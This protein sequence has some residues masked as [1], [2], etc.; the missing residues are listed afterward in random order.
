MS[1][2]HTGHLQGFDHAALRRGWQVYKEVC[3]ACHSLNQLHWRQLVGVVMTEEEAKE[4]AAEEEY[5]D[6][7]NGEGEIED[8]PGKL[9]DPLPRPYPNE[10]AAR[11]GNNGAYPPDLSLISKAREAGPDY[12][13]GLMTGYRDPPAGI[14]LR[15]GLY[16]NVYF[17]GGAIAMTQ[18]LS[19]EMIEYE[20]GTESSVSQMAKD[21]AVFL[22]W[23]AEPEMDQRKKFG[24]K[25]IMLLTMMSFSTL[26]WRRQK[27]SPL[28]TRVISFTQQR[29]V[30]QARR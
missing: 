23:A 30:H 11:A 18:P 26:Y 10:Q 3:A 8:R 17:P 6:E 19:D 20:D 9:S 1:W 24:L 13:F 5:P 22:N 27:W 12:V 14:E 29:P 16:Y 28:K 15:E 4:L 21:V 2:S 7:P 25:A